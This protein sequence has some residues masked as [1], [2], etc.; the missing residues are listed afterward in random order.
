MMIASPVKD[1]NSGKPLVVVVCSTIKEGQIRLPD[2]IE[3]PSDPE[4]KCVTRLKER[5][6]AVCNWVDSL[7]PKKILSTDGGIVPTALRNTI[8]AALIHDAVSDEPRVAIS[9]RQS[10]I[11][12]SLQ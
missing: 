5:T 3:P 10:P 11:E 12:G 9:P 4:G 8:Q 7:S 1:I 2:E 6:V